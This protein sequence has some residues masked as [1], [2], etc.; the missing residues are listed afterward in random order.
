MGNPLSELIILLGAMILLAAHEGYQVAALGTQHMSSSQI[1]AMGYPRAAAVHDLLYKGESK[2][3][4]LLIGQSFFVV[5]F[6]LAT[7]HLKRPR[8]V[9]PVVP[10]LG[11]VYFYDSQT[12]VF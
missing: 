3:P 8:I 7:F 6:K 2:I 5:G 10:L 4:R 11:V 1:T 9:I 12:Y